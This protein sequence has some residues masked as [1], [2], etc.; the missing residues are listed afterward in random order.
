MWNL[1]RPG[2][3]PVF[4]ALPGGFS[5]TGPPGKFLR[6]R[7]NASSAVKP[8]WAPKL[9]CQSLL[10]AL[11][12]CNCTSHNCMAFMCWHEYLSSILSSWPLISYLSLYLHTRHL[13]CSCVCVCARACVCAHS[14]VSNSLRPHGLYPARLLC[15][16]DFSGKNTGVGCH[17]LLQGSSQPRDRTRVSCISSI[18]K[19]ILY[20]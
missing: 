4:P 5:S 17:F 11:Y 13:L 10:I 7:L 9:R 1:P 12:L 14:V 19:Q 6:V 15:P 3:K 18:S 2:V 20:H 16:W 8:S